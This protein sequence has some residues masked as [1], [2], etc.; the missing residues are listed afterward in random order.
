M[1]ELRKVS[2]IRTLID[3]GRS[4]F[5]IYWRIAPQ[6]A[7]LRDDYDERQIF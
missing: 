2:A 3:L 6:Q 4:V 7:R 1:S 5:C